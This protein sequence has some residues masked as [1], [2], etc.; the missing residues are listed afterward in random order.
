MRCEGEGWAMGGDGGVRPAIRRCCKCPAGHSRL[1][2]AS[3]TSKRRGV[4][5]AYFEG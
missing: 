3:I 4:R 2:G 5:A 1:I